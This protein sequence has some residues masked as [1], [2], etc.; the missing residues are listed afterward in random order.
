VR[1]L[2]SGAG[3]E[4]KG[5]IKGKIPLFFSGSVVAEDRPP[6]IMPPRWARSPIHVLA[7]FCG[8]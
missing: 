2:I 3:D 6:P 5:V 7:P 1:F 8:V 4:G